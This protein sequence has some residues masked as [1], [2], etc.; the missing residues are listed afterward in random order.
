MNGFY[1]CLYIIWWGVEIT[2]P[3]PL[4]KQIHRSAYCKYIIEAY[5][6][7]YHCIAA[8]YQTVLSMDWVVDNSVCNIQTKQTNIPS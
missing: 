7:I 8:V 5:I 1:A 3:H 4:Y 2:D 6:N